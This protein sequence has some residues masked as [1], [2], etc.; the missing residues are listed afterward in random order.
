MLLR[1]WDDILAHVDRAVADDPHSGFTTLV[2][3]CVARGHLAGASCGDSALVLAE[4][5]QEPLVLTAHQ[6]KD[7]PVGSGAA[8]FVPFAIKLHA[9]WTLLSMTDGVWKYVGWDAAL[10]AAAS[11]AEQD[12]IPPLRQRAGLPSSGALQDD[13][14]LVVLRRPG[15]LTAAGEVQWERPAERPTIAPEGRVM[16]QP[17]ILMCPPD[18]YGIEYEINP[19]MHVDHARVSAYRVSRE[20]RLRVVPS[21]R[22]AMR[23]DI[24]ILDALAR[25]LRHVRQ[26]RVRRVPQQRHPPPRPPLQRRPVE[27]RPL[28]HPLGAR[29]QRPHRGMPPR[30]ERQRLVPL[31]PRRPGLLAPLV[32]PLGVAHPV[33]QPPA[34]HIEADELLAR[35]PE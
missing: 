22:E 6:S 7:P 19:W 11:P 35:P 34:A 5:Q 18:Y 10:Q 25:P 15:R 13:F 20:G 32:V 2:T 17:R 31:A 21:R 28:E 29:D 1:H 27:Q 4:P 24:C 3:F 14:T 23:Q 30:V 8:V 26:H 9:P 33:H 16:R 12:V